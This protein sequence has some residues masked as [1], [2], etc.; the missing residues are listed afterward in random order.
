MLEREIVK[1][2]ANITCMLEPLREQLKALSHEKLNL[3]YILKTTSGKQN[4]RV[5]N[6]VHCGGEHGQVK[7]SGKCSGK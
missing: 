6:S 1:V 7:C 4:H 2:V 5:Y 3:Q